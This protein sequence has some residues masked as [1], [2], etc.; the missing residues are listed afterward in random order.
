M[1]L[2]ITN[3]FSTLNTLFRAASVDTVHEVALGPQSRHAFKF[4]LRSEFDVFLLLALN[5]VSTQP[6]P[7]SRHTDLEGLVLHHT[8]FASKTHCI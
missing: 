5:V 1:L 6:R 4:K 3:L 8:A 2:G 7:K